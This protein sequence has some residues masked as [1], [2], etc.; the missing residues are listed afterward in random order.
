MSRTLDPLVFALCL[1]APT[2]GSAFE[3]QPQARTNDV[4]PAGGYTQV[5]RSADGIGKAYMGREIASVMG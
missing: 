5:P 2:V 4:A 3:R 1:L